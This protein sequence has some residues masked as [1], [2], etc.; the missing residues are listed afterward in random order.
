VGYGQILLFTSKGRASIKAI[1]SP[2]VANPVLF[3]YGFGGIPN[4]SLPL[5]AA[6]IKK[7]SVGASIAADVS[8]N[9]AIAAGS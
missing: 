5:Q 7:H 9:R 1:Q 3:K 2:K 4:T 8:A 6:K